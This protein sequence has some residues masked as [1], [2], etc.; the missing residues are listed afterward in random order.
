MARFDVYANPIAAERSHTPYV[1]DVQNEYLEQLAS[2]IVIPLRIER[3][4]GQPLR[5]LNPLIEIKGKRLVLDTANL[6]PL[7]GHRLGTP[8][9]RI[10]A[11]REDVLNALDTLFGSF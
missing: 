7:P 2:R 1:L 9:N 10:E 4:F 8:V 6:A 11:Q 5:D 3:H